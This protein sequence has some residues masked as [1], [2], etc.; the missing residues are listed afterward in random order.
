MDKKSSGRLGGLATL[1][2]YGPDHFRMIGRMGAAAFH[3]KY[4]L[5]PTGTNNF[6]IV[7][8]ETGKIKNF[9]FYNR[10]T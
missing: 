4:S 9:I 10:S 1:T 2:K 6:I 3:R 8:R 7:N 5:Y